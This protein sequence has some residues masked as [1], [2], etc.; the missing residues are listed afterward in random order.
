VAGHRPAARRTHAFLDELS[1]RQG[2]EECP[3]SSGCSRG[4]CAAIAR[5]AILRTMRVGTAAPITLRRKKMGKFRGLAADVSQ[6]SEGTAD[7]L[8]VLELRQ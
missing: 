6:A 3:C 7:G 8:A 4:V 2:I 1:P 5:S